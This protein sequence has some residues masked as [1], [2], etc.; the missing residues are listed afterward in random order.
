MQ[1]QV[2]RLHYHHHRNI[3]YVIDQIATTET[4]QFVMEVMPNA[5]QF[6]SPTDLMGHAAQLLRQAMPHVRTPVLEFGVASGESITDLSV[7]FHD[8]T[9]F[10]F[11]SFKGLPEDWKPGFPKGAFAGAFPD[12]IPRNVKL[13]PGWFDETMPGW[14]AENEGYVD[15]IHI[16]CDLYSSTHTVLDYLKNEGRLRSGAVILFDEY[17][18]YPGW[19]EHEHKALTELFRPQD[20]EYKAFNYLGEQVVVQLT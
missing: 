17:F 19:Q 9:I 18:N 10:G 16:D 7:Y 11:D 14:L 1:W 13:V 5:L 6:A 4:A 8:R 12:K 3:R 15:F 20:Y 2:E